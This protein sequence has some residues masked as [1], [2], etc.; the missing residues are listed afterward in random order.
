MGHQPSADMNNWLAPTRAGM[1]ANQRFTLTASTVPVT[2]KVPA[3]KKRMRCFF[4]AVVLRHDAVSGVTVRVRGECIGVVYPSGYIKRRRKSV[5]IPQ[6]VCT[7]ILD[8]SNL[9]PKRASDEPSINGPESVPGLLDRLGAWSVSHKHHD[10]LPWLLVVILD[11]FAS[12]RREGVERC[13][14]V[15]RRFPVGGGAIRPERDRVHSWGDA[16]E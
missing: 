3:R 9:T 1:S 13:R 7:H 12:Q 10:F 14:L 5:H 11:I 15:A 16:D 4:P 8:V 6:E 2:V